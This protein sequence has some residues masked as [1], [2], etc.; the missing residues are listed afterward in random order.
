MARS[1]ETID[2]PVTGE[3]IDFR[4]TARDTGGESVAFDYYLRPDGFAVGKVPHVHPRQEERFDVRE[5]GLGVRIDGDEW[6]ATPEARFAIPS[7]TTHTV[8]NAGSDE[9]HAVVELRPAEAVESFFE[10]MFGLA[11]DGKTNDT[12]LPGPLQLAVIAR[13]FRGEFA[14]AGVTRPLQRS[15]ASAIAPVGR[16]VGHQASYARYS[17]GAGENTR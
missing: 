13:A 2:N 8:W 14:V 4:E 11:R 3:R 12:G 7:G 17:G 6:T 15:L 5:G 1:G 16:F 9:M 10:T